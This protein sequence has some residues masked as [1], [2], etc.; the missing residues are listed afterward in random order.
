[1][2]N[3]FESISFDYNKLIGH[4]LGNVTILK[5]LGHGNRG[6]VYI[7]FQKSLKRQVGVKILPKLDTPSQKQREQFREEAE[8]VAGLSHANIIP[9]FEMGE[10]DE[11]YFLIMQLVSGSDL[12]KLIKQR[13]KYPLPSKQVLP[14]KQSI[15]YLIQLL[16]GLGYAHSQGVIHQDI[17]PANI[18]IEQHSQRPLIADFGIAKTIQCARKDPNVIIGSPVYLSP[19]Q[20]AGEETDLRTDIYSVGVV[21]FKMLA[22]TLPR[23]QESVE[24]ILTRKIER[25]ETFFTCPPSEASPSINKDLEQI[26]L[27]AIEPSREKRYQDCFAFKDDVSRFQKKYLG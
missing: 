10:D 22:G 19:E 2:I 7:G 12:N 3:L 4:E 1:M 9:I 14:L 27:Y 5:E 13:Q 26:I 25:P 17:K 6:F 16:D 18:L 21:L 11:F 23:R 8:I 24:Q 15:N 20:A